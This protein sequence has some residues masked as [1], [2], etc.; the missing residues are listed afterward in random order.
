MKFPEIAVVNSAITVFRENG[1]DKEQTL[2]YSYGLL[3]TR[4]CQE[5]K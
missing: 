1:E 3:S 5:E 4:R 2:S